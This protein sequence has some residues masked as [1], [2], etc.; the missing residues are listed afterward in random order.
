MTKHA[1]LYIYTVNESDVTADLIFIDAEPRAEWRNQHHDP[2]CLPPSN[3]KI[4]MWEKKTIS[5]FRVE[6]MWLQVANSFTL[7]NMCIDM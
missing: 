7:I 6:E 5:V 4:N 1:L 3:R 2:H